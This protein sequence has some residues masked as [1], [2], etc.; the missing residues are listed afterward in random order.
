[1]SHLRRLLATRHVPLF[2]SSYALILNTGLNGA[3]GLLYWLAAARLYSTE[4]VGVGAGAISALMLVANIGWT[5]AQFGLMRYLPAAGGRSRALVSGMYGAALGLAIPACVVFL[6]YARSSSDLRFVTASPLSVLVFA[7]G[8]ATW[9]LFSLQDAVLIGL[10]RSPLV[11]VENAAYGAL[12]LALL[13]I[14]AASPSPWG[15]LASW[16]FGAVALVVVINGLLFRRFLPRPGSSTDALPPVGRLVRFTAGHHYVA[17]VASVPDSLVPLMVLAMLSQHDN[18]FYYAAWTVSYSMRLVA[19]NIANALTVEGAHD[20]DAMHRLVRSGARL[21]LAI[22]APMAL[23][24][25]VAAGPILGFYGSTYRAAADVLR[26]FALSLAPFTVV[27]FFVASERVGQRIAAAAVVSTVST[28]GTL[29]LDLFL[30]PRFGIAGAGAGWLIA[31]VLAAAAAVAALLRRRAGTAAVD[32]SSVATAHP[33]ATEIDRDA[34]RVGAVRGTYVGVPARA[35]RRA[36]EPRDGSR[37]SVD[38]G[39]RNR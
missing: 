17:L 31:Q 21:G 25:I 2:R 19:V 32:R 3:L 29:G 13:V 28:V 39:A 10:R 8:V 23:V 6:A 15:L 4:T 9:V 11:P 1:M 12:K 30:I 27:T 36:S 14:L 34:I 20:R 22:L 7:G 16:V 35:G 26:L 18:A 37:E 38:A 24:A 33:A 5:G